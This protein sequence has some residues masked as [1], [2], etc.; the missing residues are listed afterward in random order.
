MLAT[1]SQTEA[2]ERR[3][4]PPR[5]AVGRN[6]CSLATLASASPRGV[7]PLSED[8]TPSTQPVRVRTFACANVLLMSS[9]I[10][11]GSYRV[12]RSAGAIDRFSPL[13]ESDHRLRVMTV[14]ATRQ[15]RPCKRLDGV[16]HLLPDLLARDF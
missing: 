11:D 9:E 14:Q 7:G 1:T 16:F 8:I 4:L 5:N 3:V 15:I 12:M 13:A 10:A 6:R 2:G